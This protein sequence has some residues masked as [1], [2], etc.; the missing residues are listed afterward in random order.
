MQKG[1]ELKGLNFNK[2]DYCLMWENLE[3]NYCAILEV[4]YW[5]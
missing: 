2:E 1:E 4:E 5:W 3:S